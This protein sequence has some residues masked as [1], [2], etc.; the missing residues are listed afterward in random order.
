MYM[1]AVNIRLCI[2]A[3]ALSVAS[4]PFAKAFY[5]LS[6]DPVFSPHDQNTTRITTIDII[7]TPFF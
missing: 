4:S 1:T 7:A 5:R 3:F 6:L 2:K